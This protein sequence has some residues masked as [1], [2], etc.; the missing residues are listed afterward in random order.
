MLNSSYKNEIRDTLKDYEKP[1]ASIQIGLNYGV[2]VIILQ[3]Q[4]LAKKINF[5][6]MM[7]LHRMLLTN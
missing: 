5:Q 4:I 7:Q 6:Y 2:N 3:I 1:K